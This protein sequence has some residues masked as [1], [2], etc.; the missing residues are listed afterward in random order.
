MSVLFEVRSRGARFAAK[1]VG[2]ALMGIAIGILAPIRPSAAALLLAGFVGLIVFLSREI[3]WHF[4]LFLLPFTA[5]QGEYFE[6]IRDLKYLYLA[7]L[8]G[9]A[10][11]RLLARRKYS[12]PSSP[13]LL[14]FVV[15]SAVFL[16]ASFQAV[17][18]ALAWKGVLFTLPLYFTAYVLLMPAALNTVKRLSRAIRIV[19]IAGLLSSMFAVVQSV[20]S[21]LGI[22]VL[23]RPIY[24]PGGEVF[25]SYSFPRAHAF[26]MEPLNL[27]SFLIFVFALS[28]ALSLARDNALNIS[29]RLTQ[30]VAVFSCLGIV[31]AASRAGWLSFALV[32]SLSCLLLRKY[33]WLR[34]K[35][36][37][38]VTT[39]VMLTIGFVFVSD[40]GGAWSFAKLEI[41]QFVSGSDAA[42]SIDFEHRL[43]RL[44]NFTDVILEHPVFGNA[45]MR[46]LGLVYY[47]FIP[48][49]VQV[50]RVTTTLN[51]YL[52]IAIEEGLLGL[53]A[54]IWLVG[55]FLTRMILSLKAASP[56]W[57]PLF[58]GFLVGM[59]GYLLQLN[60]FN[61][62]EEHHFWAM[63]GL[64]LAT[65][66]MH[67]LQRRTTVSD[68]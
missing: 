64:G 26:T 35:R 33:L 16:I 59:S 37:L 10:V 15:L 47:R 52:D 23:L 60:F 67:G 3:S 12:I 42:G 32:F 40:L 55:A 65:A 48:G 22:F 34:R 27:S 50:P 20:A 30:W 58:V 25:G 11:L 21:F 29:R 36:V 53:A 41:G 4:I 68:L 63:M 1:A 44:T 46:N 9:L 51:T 49:A 56:A 5:I 38:L 17:D 39:L 8:V 18:I 54:F 28:F 13:F 45:G 43:A 66:R 2:L 7:A 62:F 19:L 61:G 6:Q 14:P 24:Q 31:V 57:Q